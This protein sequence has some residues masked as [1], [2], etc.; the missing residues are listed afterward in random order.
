M[1][2]VAPLTL[3]GTKFFGGKDLVDIQDH[4]ETRI[5]LTHAMKEFRF[6]EST[7]ARWRL[8][9]IRFEIDDFFHLIG[10]CADDNYFVIERQPLQQ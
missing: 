6:D 3:D 4:Q 2:H 5:A 10:Q 1:R 7:D 8:N 9:L